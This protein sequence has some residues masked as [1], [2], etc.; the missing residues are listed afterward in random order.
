[1]VAMLLFTSLAHVAFMPLPH[2]GAMRALPR[3]S[4]THERMPRVHV[5]MDAA[6]TRIPMA[7]TMAPSAGDV[8]G[9]VLVVG[10]INVDLYQ[11]LEG[12]QAKFSGTPLSIAPIKGMTLP[13]ASFVGT[14]AV[15]ADVESA[16]LACTSGEEEGFVLTMDGPFT[17]KTGGKGANAASAA[18]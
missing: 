11:R 2:G 6:R 5:R 18:A 16:G 1:M 14:P 4:E 13:A 15:K 12:G 17:Q 9:R 3:A 7:A 10:S 8:K